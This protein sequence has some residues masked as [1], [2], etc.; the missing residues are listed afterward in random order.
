MFIA[1]VVAIIG[2]LGAPLITEVAMTYRVP[3]DSAQ[4]TLTIA[5]LSGATA[6]PVAGRLG[7]G[8]H[9]RTVILAILLVAFIGS[10]LTVIPLPFGFL[11]VGRG[12]QG[13]GLSLTALTMGVAR[14]RLDDGKA[15]KT[16]SLLSVASTVGIGIGYP[17]AGFLTYIAGLRVAYGL[18]VLITGL[19]LLIGWLTIP[20]APATHSS[21][22]DIPETVILT[23]ALLLLLVV[24]GERRIWSSMLLGLV[25]LILAC[26]LFVL[27]IW[28]D[29]RS[30]SP[31]ID[32]E[33]LRHPSVVGANFTMFFGGIGMYLLLTLVTRYVQTPLSAGYGSGFSA[34]VLLSGLVLV[35][36]SIFGFVGGKLM[37][38][39]SR[40]MS[41]SAIL[42]SSSLVVFM[43]FV[44]FAME[45]FRFWESFVIIGLLGLGV[46]MFSAAMSNVII[47]VTPTDETSSA[48]S[49]NQVVRSVAFSIGSALGGLLLSEYTPVGQSFPTELGYTT[50]AWIGS[51][52][53]LFSGIVSLGLMPGLFRKK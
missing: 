22:V 30:S 6:T 15:T 26:L 46:G 50:A 49:F 29:R 28:Q 52:T 24:I 10:I 13:I 31:L 5:L 36:F 1:L 45:R 38:F 18:G 7:T 12:A 43:G 3:L 20:V 34:T 19:A 4:W 35:P 14:D 11:L 21:K 23:S 16:I 27:W 17:L 39:L 53:V 32:L 40:R 48:M 47:R 37:P 41:S 9:R 42:A 2:S 44:F 8:A 51:L 25:L 33:L